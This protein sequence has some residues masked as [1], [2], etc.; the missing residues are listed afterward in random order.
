MSKSI[1]VL[2]G[3]SLSHYHG[4]FPHS[5][6]GVSDRYKCTMIAFPVI[7]DLAFIHVRLKF[8]NS[9]KVSY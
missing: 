4:Q 5:G 8:E 7:N 9:K 6:Y 1:L 3:L 2:N